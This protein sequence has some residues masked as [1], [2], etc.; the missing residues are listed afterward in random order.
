MSH[1]K[2]PLL[3]SLIKLSTDDPSRMIYWSIWSLRGSHLHN[4]ATISAKIAHIMMSTVV[5][6][7]TKSEQLTSMDIKRDNHEGANSVELI[8]DPWCPSGASCFSRI[9]M[10]MTKVNLIKNWGFMSHLSD[11]LRP[12]GGLLKSDRWANVYLQA[13]V[14]N[15]HSHIIN[16]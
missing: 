13:R 3:S 14:E 4:N 5:Q 7:I 9:E 2:L 8:N 1:E 6:S 10:A 15:F 12:L 16:I 11:Q